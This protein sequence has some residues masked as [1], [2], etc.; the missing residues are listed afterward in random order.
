MFRSLFLY[1]LRGHSRRVFRFLFPNGYDGEV[2]LCGGAF[3]PVLKRGSAVHDLDLWVRNRKEREKLCKALLDRGAH[4]LH[5]FHPYC[6]KFRLEGQII[7]ITYHNVKDGGIGDVLNTFDLGICGIGARYASGNLAE[8]HV[9]DACW[10]SLETRQVSV[11]DS[12]FCLLHLQKT[13]SVLR[14]LHRMGQ[15]A[16][17]LDFQ[18]DEDCE[19]RLWDLYWHEFTEEE[20]RASMDLY[21]D[22]MVTYKGQHDERLVSRAAGV[23]VPVIRSQVD[24]MPMR[25]KAK[26]A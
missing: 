24:N 14:T 5:D 7:E 11:L 6:I 22:T 1:R 9:S 8:V 13:P 15:H 20:R 18:V 17:E 16:A 19:H 10:Q 3:K 12:Y 25:L 23:Y 4:L 21:F 2:F 26:V